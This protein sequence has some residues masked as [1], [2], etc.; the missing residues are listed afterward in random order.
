MPKYETLSLE[1]LLDA[2]EYHGE[3]NLGGFWLISPIKDYLPD[4]NL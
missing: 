1:K 4:K 2:M 3:S